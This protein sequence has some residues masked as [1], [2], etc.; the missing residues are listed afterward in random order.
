[1]EA[2]TTFNPFKVPLN[3]PLLKGWILDRE[4][5]EPVQVTILQVPASTA[6]PY[7]I[8]RTPFGQ[9]ESINYGHV[10]ATADEVREAQAAE[11]TNRAMCVHHRGGAWGD[12]RAYQGD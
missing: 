4:T 9:T 6:W 5:H 7:V 11:I 12:S 8:R 2:T 10:F 1:M 3:A